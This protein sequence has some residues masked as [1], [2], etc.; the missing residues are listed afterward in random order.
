VRFHFDSLVDLV[1]ADRV[2]IQQVLLNLIRNAMDAMEDSQHR[3]LM[4]TVRPED[5]THAR[6]SVADTGSGIVPD[7]AEQ[8]FQP[9]ITTKRHGMGVG[10]SISRTIVEA[11]GGRIWVEP[12]PS[13]G[14]IFSFTLQAVNAEDVDDAN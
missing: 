4:I 8:L 10:L 6:V 14:T 2:Q 9:F 5:R 1:L 3:E 12:N 11:H 13:G 7:I